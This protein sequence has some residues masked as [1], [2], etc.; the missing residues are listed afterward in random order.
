[1]TKKKTKEKRYSINLSIDTIVVLRE[2]MS[3]FVG[4]VTEINDDNETY[5]LD[6]VKTLPKLDKVIKKHR[7]ENKNDG[8]KKNA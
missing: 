8:V 2:I 6:Y 1:M 3:E 7:E 5:F 4:K